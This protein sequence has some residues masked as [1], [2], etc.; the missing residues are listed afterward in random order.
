MLG[1]NHKT[2]KVALR[3]KVAFSAGALNLALN[4]LSKIKVS[5]S[6]ILSTCNRT[7]LYCVL[8]NGVDASH[9]IYWLSDYHALDVHELQ[10]C[11]YQHS[12]QDAVTHLMR[13]ACGLDSLVLGEPQILGQ[14][15]QA[16]F[17][18]RDAG[19]IATVFQRLFQMTFSAAKRVRSETEI[20]AN[21]VSVAFAAVSLAKHIFSDLK[22]SNVMLI[23]AGETIELV[24]RHLVEQGVSNI[25]VANRTEQRAMQLAELFDGS[26]VTL[27]E[28]PEHLHKADIV[29]SSTGS[30]LPILGKGM[31][32]TALKQRKHRPMLLIDIA[33]PRDIEAEVAEL[34]DA[35]LYTVDDL[36]ELVQNNL[37][38]RQVAAQHAEQIVQEE[39]QQFNAWQESLKS[40]DT[41]RQYRSQSEACRDELV[42]KALQRLAAGS[43]AEAV[44]KEL[45]NKLTNKLIHAPT[46]ALGQASKE[47][48]I[49]RVEMLASSLGVKS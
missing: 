34:A 4:S 20:G 18:A 9:I 48:L 19:V 8:D 24:A 17:E 29:I 42:N 45:G 28:I 25:Q 43:D 7:E 40:I 32:E 22:Q 23:G 35:Y 2:A 6:V 41:L 30:P 14:L 15:K 21:A 44:I 11:I 39:Q 13:V 12:G 38:S 3:E 31:V 49:E 10:S 37:E 16:F 36:Q 1:I 47:G 27:P 46:R 5:E 26:V 33:V